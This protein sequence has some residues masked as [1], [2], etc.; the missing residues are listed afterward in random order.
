[1]PASK[2][3]S[4]SPNRL[5]DS[6][7]PTKMLLRAS[8][9]RDDA[10][11]ENLDL[12]KMDEDPLIYFLTPTP[13]FGED[14]DAMDLDLEFDAGIEDAKHPPQ[15]VR[16]VSPSSLGG[17]LSRPPPVPAPLS[18]S[19]RPATPPR[20]PATPDLEYDLSGTPDEHDDK[21]DDEGYVHAHTPGPLGLPRRLRHLAAGKLRG[22]G[23]NAGLSPPPPPAV[24]L[25]PPPS[26][27]PLP[28]PSSSS[29]PSNRGRVETSL[30]AA[31]PS[32]FAHSSSS[33]SSS[34][35]SGRRSVRSGGAGGLGAAGAVGTAA[36]GGGGE[37]GMRLSP[38]AWREPS[39]DVWSIEEETEEELRRGGSG[40][41]GDGRGVGSRG[42][43]EAGDEHETAGLDGPAAKPSR[44]NKNMKKKVRF[45]LP[46]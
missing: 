43:S 33:P 9:D 3:S 30:D 12:T 37:N 36:G 21:D 17:G 22:S 39:P 27:S 13:S 38:H 40:G 16:S 28:S 14:G 11:V 24:R 44:N 42:A 19:P 26:A 32:S 29:S 35:S 31:G 23:G 18:S 5:R 6:W 10:E 20:S 8:A 4:S 41:G 1:M 46:A 25:S 34:P 15:I 7:P 45:V 2:S